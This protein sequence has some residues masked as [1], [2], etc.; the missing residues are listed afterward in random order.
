MD[1]FQ[2]IKIDSLLTLI[3]SLIALVISVVALYYT[4]ITFLMKSGHKI[5]CDIRTCSSIACEDK[6]VST[7]TLENLKDRSTVI[8]SIYLRLGRGNYILLEDFDKEPL[9]LKPFEVYQKSYEPII[10]Y[11]SGFKRIKID[12]LLSNIDLTRSIILSTTD[13]QYVVKTRTKK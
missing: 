7:I 8:F 12:K 6:Y 1:Q 3:I 10:L 5:R 11:A 4:V 9:I 2:D 13:G